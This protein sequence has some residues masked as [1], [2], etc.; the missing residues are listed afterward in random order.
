MKYD[1]L[2]IQGKPFVL[3]PLH[4]YRAMTGSSNDSKL[5]EEILDQLAAKK[6]SAVKIIRKHR[7]MTQEELAGKAGISRPYLTEIETKRKDG[8]VRAIKALAEILEVEV[9]LLT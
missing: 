2:H 9:G 3:I 7:G 5:P 6:A 4:D 1:L 8:S